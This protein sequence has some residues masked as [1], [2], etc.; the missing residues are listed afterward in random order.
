MENKNSGEDQTEKS[1]AAESA[2]KSWLLDKSKQIKQERTM[3]K[4]KLA[5]EAASYVIRDRS[6][7]DEAFD[8]YV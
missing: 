2:Y 8:R 5:E 7:C 6:L 1:K 4:Y 3:E